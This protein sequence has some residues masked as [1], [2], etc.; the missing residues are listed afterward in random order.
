MWINTTPI[1][2]GEILD[3]EPQVTKLT[4][5]RLADLVRVPP[6]LLYRILAEKRSISAE[7][8]LRLARCFGTSAG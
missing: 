4:A 3:D 5:R 1:H 6:N 7:T 8:D 2:P